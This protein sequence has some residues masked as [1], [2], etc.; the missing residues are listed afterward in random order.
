MESWSP[1]QDTWSRFARPQR[2]RRPG[3]SLTKATRGRLEHRIAAA[4]RAGPLFLVGDAAHVHSPAGG[5][6]MNTGIQDAANLGWKLAFASAA[7]ARAGSAPEL[8][9][10]SYE[11]ERRPVGGQVMILTHLLYWGEAGT[12]TLAS[13]VRSRL[14]PAVAPAIPFLLKRRRLMAAGVRVLSQLNVRY[15]QSP[16]SMTGHPPGRHGS[17]PGERGPDRSS[18]GLTDDF[19]PAAHFL[20][21]GDSASVADYPS[22]RTPTTPAPLQPRIRYDATFG[23]GYSGV[24]AARA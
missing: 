17:R 13:V 3:A 14:L 22:G 2:E 18:V 12:G 15:Q 5:Q 9:L 23:P 4:Y 6:G 7:L 16:I 10:A 1:Q 19:Q 21:I 24:R 11:D 20:G 8:L